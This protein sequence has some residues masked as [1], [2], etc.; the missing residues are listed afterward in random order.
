MSFKLPTL[1]RPRR[2]NFRSTRTLR[3]VLLILIIVKGLHVVWTWPRNRFSLWGNQATTTTPLWN[4]LPGTTGLE[5]NAGRY[6]RPRPTLKR[7]LAKP[8]PLCLVT[9]WESGSLPDYIRTSLDSFG[10]AR[11]GE[12]DDAFA[13][14]Y[15][16]F[17]PSMS[18]RAL[19]TLYGGEA[20]WPANVH[21]VDIGDVHEDWK[22]EGWQ[23]FVGDHLCRLYG[24]E[25]MSEECVNLGKM[26]DKRFAEGG[27][28]LVQLRPVYGELFAPW[29]ST[30]R[31]SSWAW[32]DLDTVWGD[33]GGL[34]NAPLYLT[35]TDVFTIGFG[36][37]NRVYTRGQLT[38][39]NQHKT[40]GVNTVWRKCSDLATIAAAT[41]FFGRDGWAALDEGCTT[42]AVIE[43]GLTLTA[44]PIQEA[45]WGAALVRFENGILLACRIK[46][47]TPE[48]RNLCRTAMRDR[49]RALGTPNR[50]S[51]FKVEPTASTPLVLEQP[52]GWN[53]TCSGWL[54]LED[55][56]CVRD[57]T[58]WDRNAVWAQ[59]ITDR[60]ISAATRSVE[61]K[62]PPALDP[63]TIRVPVPSSTS[64]AELE[65]LEAVV[66]HMQSWKK[67]LNVT[68]HPL[69]L[70]ARALR[71]NTAAI[72]VFDDVVDGRSNG[73]TIRVVEP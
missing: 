51:P 31:C 49:A 5:G 64:T 72:E 12:G 66:F 18:I 17:P 62:H 56:Y 63:R 67:R 8:T 36:D 33:L 21:A 35:Q 2:I 69:E 65:I 34:L 19:K 52:A 25:R 55:T 44:V 6:W 70:N 4:T 9:M 61:Y 68:D 58:L 30:S 48:N 7:T 46:E 42:R 54:P 60:G 45:D 32:A 15:F 50:I 37:E 11:Q 26:V 57:G 13:E 59:I 1:S 53:T 38:G 40:P 24:V 22:R 39:F 23:G 41:A 71:D 20:N 16:F 29:I 47:N 27:N 10:A 43:S 14:L 3:L 28:P 73:V